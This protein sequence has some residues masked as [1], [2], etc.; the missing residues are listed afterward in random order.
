M[1]SRIGSEE[2]EELRR[3]GSRVRPSG[4]AVR[5]EQ[6][7]RATRH[8]ET[9]CTHLPPVSHHVAFDYP[10]GPASRRPGFLL[11]EQRAVVSLKCLD[12]LRRA[13]RATPPVR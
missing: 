9:G 4:E 7:G 12:S 8:L 2:L 3:A 13:G 5:P 1:T 10:Q 11:I 6:C